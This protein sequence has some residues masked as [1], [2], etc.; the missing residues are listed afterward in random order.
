MGL[1]MKSFL[2]VKVGGEDK[3]VERKEVDTGFGEERNQKDS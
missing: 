3:R 1:K 2:K